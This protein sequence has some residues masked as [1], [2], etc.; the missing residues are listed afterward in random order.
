MNP[1]VLK[2]CFTKQIHET[3]RRFDNLKFKESLNGE[4][5]K[6]NV[7]DVNYEIFHDILL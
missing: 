1:T 3:N 5:V 7:N 4:L 2:T 6:H